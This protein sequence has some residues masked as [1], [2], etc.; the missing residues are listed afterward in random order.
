MKVFITGIGGFAGQ[1]LARFLLS[2]GLEVHGTYRPDTTLPSSDVTSNV[3]SYPIDLLDAS[4]MTAALTS[5]GPDLVFHLAAQASV[6]Q[7]WRDPEDTYR[8]NVMGQLTL[9]ESLRKL[10]SPPRTLVAS[11]NEV[12]GAPTGPEE[13]P[14]R[15]SNPLRP[16]NPYAVSKAAQDLMA[17]QYARSY[18]QPIVRVRA[19]NHTGPGQSDAFVTSAFARQVAEAEAGLRE[20]VVRVGNLEAMRDFTDVRD[21]VRGYHDVLLNGVPGEV[22]NLGSGKAVTIQSILDFLVARSRVPLQVERDPE[23]M[24]PAD[25]PCVYA[26]CAKAEQA[27]GWRPTIPLEQTLSDVLEYWRAQVATLD[28][29]SPSSPPSAP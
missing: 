29:P 26:D 24:W 2:R 18:G 13:L 20:P 23:R 10:P 11:S 16:S 12:Y 8:T 22:Y 17:Y 21:M 4:A 5:V 15:E 14:I 9:L 27:T 25:V 7:S 19:F 3:H 28:R 6:P 1:H